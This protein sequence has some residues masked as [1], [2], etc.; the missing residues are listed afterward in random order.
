MYGDE[1]RLNHKQEIIGNESNPITIATI[2]SNWA[3]ENIDS[4]YSSK[5]LLLYLYYDNGSFNYFIRSTNAPWVIKNQLGNCGENSYYFSEMM[6]YSGISSRIVCVAEDHCWSEF[7]YNDYWNAL[8][9]TK[10]EF[11]SDKYKFAENRSWTYVTARYLNG[12]IEDITQSYLDTNELTIKTKNKFFKN[13]L[14]I[15]FLSPY[16]NENNGEKYT[17]YQGIVSKKINSEGFTKINIAENKEIEV[18]YTL[19]LF[20]I[21]FQKEERVLF[22]ENRIIELETFEIIS[23]KNI[24]NKINLYTLII[25]FSVMFFIWKKLKNKILNYNYY[26]NNYK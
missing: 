9:T 3:Y 25:T 4:L 6:I 1:I 19:S 2:Y 22:D 24:F 10:N 23:W 5:P 18:R 11:I 13:N 7:K 16:L 21:S 17:T 26:I 14:K 8:D 12:T 15:D 20:I